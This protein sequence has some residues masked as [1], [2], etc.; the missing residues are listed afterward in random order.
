[1]ISGVRE[2]SITLSPPR[3]LRTA[4]VAI[5]VFGQSDYI[6]WNRGEGVFSRLTVEGTS[7]GGSSA[8]WAD[9]DGAGNLLARYLFGDTIDQIIARFRRY[10]EIA[11]DRANWESWDEATW[12]DLQVLFNLAWTD[13]DWLAEEPLA[14]LRSRAGLHRTRGI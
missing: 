1:M 5:T 3:R 4:D 11:D 13:P 10:Q 14:A 7:G 9:Y 6:L 12:R 2:R 8:A